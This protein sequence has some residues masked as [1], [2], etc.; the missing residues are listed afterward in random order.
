MIHIIAQLENEMRAVI[1]QGKPL[2]E[3]IRVMFERGYGML[4]LA[5]AVASIAAVDPHTA[6][7]I[8]LEHTRDLREI[9]SRL[10]VLS[11]KF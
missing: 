2:D 7:K 10:K 6:K 5:D 11:S 3:A 1:A 4:L 8:V 9:R